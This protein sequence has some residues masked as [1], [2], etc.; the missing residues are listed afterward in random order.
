M[1]CKW[2]GLCKEGL[3]N[4]GFSKEEKIIVVSTKKVCE[5][6][7]LLNECFLA[8]F[9]PAAI[10]LGSSSSWEQLVR[11]QALSRSVTSIFVEG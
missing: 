9:S 10:A 4:E 7:G 11:L 5:K 6:N 2:N 8:S 1:V 3:L